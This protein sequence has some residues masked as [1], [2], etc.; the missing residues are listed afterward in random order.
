M[1]RLPPSLAGDISIPR[2]RKWVS[3]VAYGPCGDII[4]SGGNN[5]LLVVVW[6]AATYGSSSARRGIHD[7]VTD[8]VFVLGGHQPRGFIAVGIGC[9]DDVTLL[10]MASHSSYISLKRTLELDEVSPLLPNA[11]HSSGSWATLVFLLGSP[12][13]LS[14][15]PPVPLILAA[16]SLSKLCHACYAG[17]NGSIWS[18]TCS[19]DSASC[20]PI[21]LGRRRVCMRLWE[22]WH[23]APVKA[24]RRLGGAPPPPPP[25][26]G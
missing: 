1:L 23:G 24:A 15:P 16:H 22:V 8:P 21:E 2:P 17:N 9:G 11:R 13:F 26:I 5:G 10:L 14:P 7:I 19:P 4:V 18:L 20:L 25:V 6:D 3:S 12:L